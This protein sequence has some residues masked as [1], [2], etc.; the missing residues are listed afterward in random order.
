M[1]LRAV[2]LRLARSLDEAR[3]RFALIGGLALSAHGAARATVDLDFLAE[4]ER[5]ADVHRILLAD[6]YE[7]LY[8]SENVANYASS[9]PERG[10]VDFLFARRSY[11]QAMLARAAG[12]S[13][14]GATLRV[15]DPADLVGLKVQASS[16]DP[17]R[18]HRDLADVQSLLRSVPDLDRA[19]V[20]E[21]FR[22][23]DREKE[24]EAMLSELGR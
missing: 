1:D 13:V 11:G 6:G 7:C 12:H 4:G 23:F 15:V 3:I 10:R 16:N 17:T 14:L 20:R 5:D 2:L 24:L 18:R 21:Y 19:R 9:D 22:L 8:R